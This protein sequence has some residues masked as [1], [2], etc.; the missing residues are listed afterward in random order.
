MLLIQQVIEKISFRLRD[1]GFEV[2]NEQTIIDNINDTLK[3]I[4]RE[5]KLFTSEYL[6]TLDGS[7]E[8]VLPQNFISI[9]GVQ[10]NEKPLKIM[11]LSDGL[12]HFKKE[13]FC[14]FSTRSVSVYP[15]NSTGELKLIYNNL[16]QV[17]DGDTQI[18]ISSVLSLALIFGTMFLG[19][20]REQNAKALEKS[21]Y[22]KNL[23]EKELRDNKNLFV[24]LV[25]PQSLT[26]RYKRV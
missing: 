11:A 26:T 2:W 10:L 22:Y 23:F 5:I 25:N 17:Q 20:Q 13:T 19:L 15:Q 7:K 14:Y 12:R 9:V 4:A 8:Y 16:V 3:V 6:I 24:D 18:D 21:L 1:E